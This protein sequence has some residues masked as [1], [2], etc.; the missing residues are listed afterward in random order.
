MAPRTTS[1]RP[2]CRNDARTQGATRIAP[3]SHLRHVVARVVLTS[4]NLPV[5]IC[6]LL[7]TALPAALLHAQAKS[8]LARARELLE[9][10]AEKEVKEGADIC[11]AANN[12]AAVELMLEVLAAT[13]RR[14]PIHL[15]PGHYRDIV[16]DRLA[17]ITDR[18]AR[19]RIE[20][21]LKTGQDQ[22]VRQWCAELLGIFGD[23]SF[24]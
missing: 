15:A 5:R 10:P 17:K 23:R 19:A 14:S 6:L 13:E 3:S 16:W 11:L 20:L 24:A 18:Y 12:V 4:P 2:T 22:R 8:D 7:L 1:C 9:R 21:E